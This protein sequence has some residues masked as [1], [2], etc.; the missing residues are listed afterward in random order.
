MYIIVRNI[1][2]LKC[3]SKTT[4]HVFYLLN[5]I[6][7]IVINLGKKIYTYKNASIVRM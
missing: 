3:L 4:I 1:V 6:A 2:I 5:V 7:K